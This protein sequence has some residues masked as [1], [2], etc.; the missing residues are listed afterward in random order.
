MF[1]CSKLIFCAALVALGCLAILAAVWPFCDFIS[2]IVSFD[3]LFSK[4]KDFTDFQ[5]KPITD[6]K[7]LRP[8]STLPK[9]QQVSVRTLFSAREAAKKSPDF[10][11]LDIAGDT[12]NFPYMKGV[13]PKTVKNFEKVY[14]TFKKIEANPTIE[15]ITNRLVRKKPEKRF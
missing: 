5:F 2:S 3:N 10:F 14:P 11:S 15:I 9:G 4:S 13:D 8:Y 6:E 12:F 7:G 1:T